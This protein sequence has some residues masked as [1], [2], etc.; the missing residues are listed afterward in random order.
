MAK[1][2]VVY[3]RV[4]LYQDSV[5][6]GVMNIPCHVVWM[7]RLESAL[8]SIHQCGSFFLDHCLYV[9]GVQIPNFMPVFLA[10]K[11]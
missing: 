6:E 8:C 3:P 4:K 9:S 2:D 7:G 10:D 1:Q 11:F 5:A